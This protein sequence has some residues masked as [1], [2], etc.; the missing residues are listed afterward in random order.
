MP[1]KPSWNP[2]RLLALAGL[3]LVAVRAPT[4]AMLQLATRKFGMRLA[5]IRRIE[6]TVHE[7]LAGIVT[8]NG[9]IV[10]KV[11]TRVAWRSM[12]YWKRRCVWPSFKVGAITTRLGPRSAFSQGS[13]GCAF[14]TS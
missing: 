12:K 14:A 9:F 8:I 11:G 10:I 6:I 7:M 3:A 13:D 2:T 4:L 1:N 5:C